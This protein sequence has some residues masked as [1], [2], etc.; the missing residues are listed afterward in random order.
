MSRAATVAL[1]LLPL[2]ACDQAMQRPGMTAAFAEAS[3]S[4]PPACGLSDAALGAP[5]ESRAG[6]T[7]HDTAP[8]TTAP[9]THYITGFEDGC[10]RPVT[11]ALVMFG[12]LA[13]HETTRYEAPDGAYT[14]ADTA[15]EQ[16]KAQACGASPGQPCGDALD[17][18]AAD[19]V[20][21][22]LYPVFGQES[23]NDL[24]LHG[25]QLVAA[26]APPS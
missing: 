25:G 3:A 26:D 14:A 17:R 7:V 21:V 18:L 8:G 2:A 4:I 5:V 13:T 11:A 16:I 22:S 19:T 6:Y 10:A 23:H 24:L 9:R 20:F 1:A 12:D 15:Y